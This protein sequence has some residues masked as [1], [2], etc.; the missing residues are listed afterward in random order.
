MIK[1]FQYINFLSVELYIAGTILAQAIY[2]KEIGDTWEKDFLSIMKKYVKQYEK[3][4]R[5]NPDMVNT[6]FCFI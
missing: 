2:K 5:E 6:E 4:V 1:A 3:G